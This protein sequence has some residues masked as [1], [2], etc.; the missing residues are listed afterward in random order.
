MQTSR[1][2]VHT[3]FSFHIFLAIYQFIQLAQLG[4]QYP[5]EMAQ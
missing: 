3:V 2:F 4:L 5:L 1:P